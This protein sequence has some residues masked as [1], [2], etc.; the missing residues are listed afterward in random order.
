MSRPATAGQSFFTQRFF[1]LR[2]E[3]PPAPADF[4][5]LDFAVCDALQIG[6]AG[7]FKIL[8][9]F[10]GGQNVILAGNLFST[11]MSIDAIGDDFTWSQPGGNC[12]K[13]QGGLPVTF[14]DQPGPC[15][16]LRFGA[17]AEPEACLLE[18]RAKLSLS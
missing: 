5:G 9:G 6:R 18:V 16:I 15:S 13:G 4:F 8:A 7:Y 10:F 14:G 2:P 17:E 12:G 11:L 1:Q 3:G